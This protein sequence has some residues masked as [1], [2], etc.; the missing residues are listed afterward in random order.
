MENAN[1]RLLHRFRVAGVT[2]NSEEENICS[3]INIDCGIASNTS[4]VHS[5]TG[6]TYVSDDQYI[7]T[8]LN[9]KISS[10][11]PVNKTMYTDLETLRSFPQ[12]TRNCYTLAPVRNGSEYLVRALFYYGNYDGLEQSPSF[13]LYFGVNFWS[14]ISIPEP[15]YWYYEEIVAVATANYIHACLVN[16]GHGNPF[17]STLEL[18]P[19]PSTLYSFAWDTQF[20]KLY[21]RKDVGSDNSVVRYP[22]DNYDRLWFNYTKSSWQKISTSSSVN[23]S[24]S[25]FSYEVPSSVLKTAAVPSTES[26]IIDITWSTSNSSTMFYVILHFAEIQIVQNTS[27]REFYIYANGKQKLKTPVL[28][29]YLNQYSYYYLDIGQT[30]YNMSLQSSPNATLPP[31][32]NAFELYSLESATLLPTD[33]RDVSAIKSIKTN[34]SIRKDWSGDPCL[35]TNYIWT[36]ISCIIYA[37]DIPRITVLNLS[38]SQLTGAIISEFGSLTNLQTLDLSHN[39]LSGNI[40]NSLDQLTSLTFLDLSGNSGLSG[41]LP[42]G[43]QKKQNDHHLIVL[44]DSSNSSNSSNSTES[45]SGHKKSSKAV[46]FII[47]A[48]VIVLLIAGAGAFFFLYRKKKSTRTDPP[49]FDQDPR[50]I[51]TEYSSHVLDDPKDTGESGARGKQLNFDKRQFSFAELKLVTNDFREKIG[52]GGFGEVFKGRLEN[53]NDVAVKIC[54][55][56]SS[57]GTQ[58]FLN[59]VESLSRVHHK[60]LV[61]LVGYCSDENHI[62]LIYEYMEHGNL[63]DRLTGRA[64]PL[65]WKQ[66]LRIAYESAQGLEYLHKMCNP[67]LIHR[68]VKTSNILLTRNLMA[69]V[70]DFGLVRTFSGTHVSTKVFGTPGYLDPHYASTSQLIER[71]DV[72]SFGVVLLEIVTGK[73]PI[74]QGPQ[75]REHLTK[76]VQKKISKG[77]IESILDPYMGGQYNINSIWKVAELAL[78]CTDLPDKRPDMTQVVAELKETLSLEMSHT[79]TVSEASGDIS[80]DYQRSPRD[81]LE[82]GYIGGSKLPDYGPLLR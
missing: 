24:S 54:S 17:I 45:G 43:L 34:Y 58:Q 8:G 10:K 7:D 60:N 30:F 77:N 40:P 14:T 25:I 70:S 55:E 44:T 41:I 37:S 47:V 52:I 42:P 13:D 56:L 23:S 11:Y 4:Y 63:Q 75:G 80:S 69:Q 27:L 76:F 1:R 81:N 61:S 21:A 28:I 73:M 79:E 38:S 19:L 29:K 22:S 51:G 39:N 15:G 32:L 72:Y 64:H 82:M 2:E 26:S 53:G 36:G 68:D 71:S 6:L 78:R 35:P 48:V 74:C 59:E 5:F 62:A 46:I 49:T 9:G 20:I 16:T 65:S 50:T 66:R 12:G 67:P 3:F 57:Q 18:R 31:M 33:T